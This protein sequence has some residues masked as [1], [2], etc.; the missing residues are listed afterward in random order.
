MKTK[1]A[2]KPLRGRKNKKEDNEDSESN[3][4]DDEYCV[5]K[6]DDESIDDD[7]SEVGWNSED[8]IMFGKTTGSKQVESDDDYDDDDCEGAIMLSDMLKDDVN[9]SRTDFL[10]K[11]HD[12]SDRDD[13]D[14]AD[15]DSM[16][17]GGSDSGGHDMLLAAIEKFSQ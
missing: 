8:D 17:S 4:G 10:A 12:D 1:K 7:G 2:R 9:P 11:S 16:H 5:T 14:D 3:S 15:D 6:A 13:G